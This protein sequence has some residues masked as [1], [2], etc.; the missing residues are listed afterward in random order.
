VGTVRRSKA[1]GLCFFFLPPSTEIFRGA[2]PIVLGSVH[3]HPPVVFVDGKV[4]SDHYLY[5]YSSERS[6]S[7]W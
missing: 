6:H 3:I 5:R 1:E 4:S 2:E 7:L